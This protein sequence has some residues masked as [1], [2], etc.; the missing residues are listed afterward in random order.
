MGGP[1]LVFPG[2]QG[3]FQAAAA[4]FALRCAEGGEVSV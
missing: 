2:S 3:R 1:R 4:V